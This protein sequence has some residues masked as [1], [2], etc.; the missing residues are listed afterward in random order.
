MKKII[1]TIAALLLAQTMIFAQ[2]YK[3]EGKQF[4]SASTERQ[5]STAEKTGFTWKERDGSVY[6]IYITKNNAC[7][8]LKVSKKTGKE[9]KKY[10]PKEVAEQ[11]TKELGR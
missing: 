11:I 7:Y 10:L 5:S 1:I 3:R 8:I 9:Y 4:S 2:D 6:D